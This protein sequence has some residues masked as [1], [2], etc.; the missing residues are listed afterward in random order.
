MLATSKSS[1]TSTCRTW[2]PQLGLGWHHLCLER[3]SLYIG[4]LRSPSYLFLSPF[5]LDHP[6]FYRCPF[7]LSLF[8][9][10]RRPTFLP[11][12]PCIRCSAHSNN[13]VEFLCFR[14][15]LGLLS[16]FSPSTGLACSVLVRPFKPPCLASAKQAIKPQCFRLRAVASVC[17]YARSGLLPRGLS[18]GN[19]ASALLS[20]ILPFRTHQLGITSNA[21]P[22]L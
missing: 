8:A 14:G 1:L 2:P 22:L 5:A 9:I 12:S 15:P 10:V 4:S 6:P 18:F 20:L 21:T 17:L 11:R 19:V 13:S 3:I 7:F 16:P